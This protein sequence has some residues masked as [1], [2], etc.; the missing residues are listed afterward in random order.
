MINASLI[1]ELRGKTGAGMLDC[2]KALEETNGNMEEAINYLRKKGATT[3][4]KKAERIAAEG[5]SKILI[6]DN[7]AVVLE[8]NCETDFASKN[9]LFTEMFDKIA[10]VLIESDA[11]TVEEALEL[12]IYDVTIND[13]IVDKTAT[14]GE[15][16]SFRRFEVLTKEN[17]EVFGSYSHMDGKISVISLIKGDNE[18]VAKDISMHAAAMRP[19]YIKTTDVPEDVVNKEKEILTEEVIKEGKPEHIAPR[20]VEGKLGK[21]FE[22]IVLEEQ[23]FIK[24]NAVKIKDYIKNNKSEIINLVRYEVGEGLEKRVEN[25]E[26]EVMSQIKN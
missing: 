6:K 3:A 24:D 15:K 14:I 2:K 8:I 16:L 5:L 11:T 26:E 7:K 17:D 23:F 25:F 19:E 4:A 21:F 20:I 9:D 22:G 12:K 10:E 1:S 13:Y 18:E